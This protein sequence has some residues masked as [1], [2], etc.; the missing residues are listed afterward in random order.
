[1]DFS[2]FG[3]AV[4]DVILNIAKGVTFEYFPGLISFAL[5]TLLVL[6]LSWIAWKAERRKLLVDRLRNRIRAAGGPSGFQLA[7]GEIQADLYRAT[8]PDA[9]RLATAFSEFR[10]TLI[11]PARDGEA[12]VRN[13]IRPSTFI[14]L[15]DLRFSL[16]SWRVLPG[17]FVS[18]G[19]LLTFLGLIAALAATKQSIEVGGGD[20][21]KMMLA[22]EGL[23]DTAS[24]KFTMSLTGL[25]CSIVFT[26]VLRHLSSRLERSMANLNHEIESC[27]DF[28]SLESLAD[29]Q[30]VAIKEQTAQQ[31]LLNMELIAQLSKPLERMSSGGVEA[32]SA[33][34]NELG[35]SL[36]STISTSLDQFANRIEGASQTLATLSDS[37]GNASRRFEEN[38]ERSIAGLD[39][40]VQRI[41]MVT[42]KLS[43]AA[44]SVA[45]TTTPV[46][47][48]AKATADTARSLATGSM[49]LIEAAKAAVDAERAVVV[50][51]ATSIEGLVRAFEGRAKAYDG[52]LERAFA[53]YLEQVQSTLG[54][55][56]NHS[57]GVHDR[58]GEALHVLKAVIDNA[59]TFIPESKSDGE[60]ISGVDP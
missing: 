24:A 33:M 18:T 25:F 19:L 42:D 23:L 29:R 26:V 9:K 50:T 28:V 16:S 34:A 4:R 48:T 59:R 57:D 30:L 58:F 8:G 37:L 56:K 40:V 49:G 39:V 10:E 2:S 45:T 22:L 54:E 13:G 6:L 36:S 5:L 1:M 11:E 14:N 20:Q 44:D 47:E 3:T 41:A 15:E 60:G 51:S 21:Q 35:A 31:Q 32:M 46:M 53:T 7:L 55:L 12:N 38:V 43:H 52:Q 27:M 17:L